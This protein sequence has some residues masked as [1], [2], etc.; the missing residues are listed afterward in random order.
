MKKFNFKIYKNNTGS[1]L[2][3]SL[4]TDIPFK[5]KRIFIIYGNKNSLRADHAH[6]K[7][8]QFLVPI[9]GKVIVEYE[10]K[11]GKFKKDLSFKK[12]ETLLLKPKTWCRV[13]FIHQYSKLMVFCDRE[14]EFNDYIEKYN[15]FLKIIKKKV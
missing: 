12:K 5:V 2:P 14:Y 8:S 13:K 10:N 11:N 9:F 7:C 4:K 1:L 6:K 15:H 3:L